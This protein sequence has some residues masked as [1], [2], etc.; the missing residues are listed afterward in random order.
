VIGEWR[1]IVEDA[2]GILRVKL[3]GLVGIA[4]APGGA[5][6]VGEL[7][8]CGLIAGLL[9]R[10]SADK[11]EKRAGRTRDRRREASA[12]AR[13]EPRIAK[14]QESSQDPRARVSS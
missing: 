8:E 3:G 4:G 10:A 2:A 5:V 14:Q 7:A 11:S 6:V 1:E 9:L 13:R 12:N